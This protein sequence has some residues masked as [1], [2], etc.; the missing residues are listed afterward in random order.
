[1]KKF[2]KEIVENWN[3]EEWLIDV[4]V[5]ASIYALLISLG[6]IFISDWRSSAQQNWLLGQI[7]GI[8]IDAYASDVPLAAGMHVLYPSFPL[9]E[10]IRDAF[11]AYKILQNQSQSTSTQMT[12]DEFAAFITATST[13]EEMS[14]I[15]Q[16]AVSWNKRETFAYYLFLVCSMLA[17]LSVVI[18]TIRLTKLSSRN[19]RKRNSHKPH[20]AAGKS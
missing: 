1:M 10:Y 6:F 15:Y 18:L 2:L 8:R 9:N 14:K 5:V 3:S 17:Q 4:L 12:Y 13:N 16:G 20:S 19:K 11:N 7:D